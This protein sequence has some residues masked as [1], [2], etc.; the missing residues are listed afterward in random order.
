MVV[1]GASY[2]IWWKLVDK[3]RIIELLLYGSFIAVCRVIFDNW[4]ISSGR[5]I[6]TV[7][8]FPLGYSL[9]LNDLTVMPLALMLVYQ[10]SSNWKSFFIRLLIVQGLISVILWP[11][12]SSLNILKL[13]DWQLYYSYIAMILIASIMRL[14]IIIGLN[15][16]RDSQLSDSQYGVKIPMAK[17]AMK[18]MNDDDE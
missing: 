15:V 2:A 5:W 14:V 18:R 6:Y 7:D 16:Q 10:Y 1:I 8:L 3:R 17:P 11:I 13:Y 12:L 4:G 9:F